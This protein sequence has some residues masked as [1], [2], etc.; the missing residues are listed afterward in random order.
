[1][2]SFPP[3]VLGEIFLACIPALDNKDKLPAYFPYRI[4]HVCRHWRTSAL[5]SPKLWSFLDVEQTQ[6]NE[7]GNCAELF[8]MEA[9]LERSGKHPLTFRLRIAEETMHYQTFL[10]CLE[11]H[12]ARWQDVFLVSPDHYTLE[13]LAQGEPSNYP[14]L[15]SLVCTYGY[16]DSDTISEGPI[17]DPIPW[18]QLKRYHEHDVSWFPDCERQWE[19]ISELTAV[20]DLRA[21]FY[22]ESQYETVIEMPDLRFA[23]LAIHK[24][25]DELD[26]EDIINCF[27]FPGI[28]GLNLKLTNACPADTLSPLPNQLKGLKILRLCGSLNSISNGALLGILTEI[29]GLTDL[30][31]ELRAVDAPH[32]FE[33]LTPTD[34]ETVLL[35]RLRALRT[36]DF[37]PVVD[38]QLDALLEMLHQRFGQIGRA[39]CARLERFEFL[40]G[41]RPSIYS[42]PLDEWEA[43]KNVPLTM[44]EKLE[45][46]R[47][48]EGWDIRV[49]TE[50]KGYDFWKE[51]MDGEFL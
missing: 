15:R 38:A 17:F 42:I 14:M 36:T 6:E 26:I 20:V 31:L 2:A 16:F 1:M 49:D 40:L 19:I 9:Y 27:D 50:W 30:A 10:E 43:S 28:Q 21:S 39:G 18:G 46:L 13:H 8:L 23:S 33:L 32:L 35:P 44:F 4:S 11:R 41:A 34:S 25:A 5:A 47:A 24:N 45:E 22:D 7:E 3:E 37:K 51:E 48:S 29:E 12:T